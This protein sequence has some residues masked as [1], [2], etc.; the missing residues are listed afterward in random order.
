MDDGQ[1]SAVYRPLW[2]IPASEHPFPMYPLS[3]TEPHLAVKPHAAMKLGSEK[4]I[5]NREE[6]HPKKESA[7]D[8]VPLVIFTLLAQLSVGAFWFM[9]LLLPKPLTILPLSIIGFS[10]GIGM[11]FSFA[12][13]GTKKNAWRV[14]N[15]LNKSWLSREILTAS[16][17]GAGWLAVTVESLTFEQFTPLLLWITALLGF[18]LT[19]S[20]GQVYRLRAKP[21]WNT[22]RT[23][24][25][26]FVSALLL[27]LTISMVAGTHTRNV[28]AIITTCVLLV[29]Q[30]VV[31][32]RF[33][34]QPATRIMQL[35]SYL[36]AV[37]VAVM[38]ILQQEEL[39]TELCLLIFAF[40]L[41]GETICRLQF[42]AAKQTPG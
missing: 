38:G 17:F 24:A 4:K 9:S 7:W 23:N 39:S 35:G 28:A 40:V 3:R 33:H 29:L 19:Y 34:S 42:Y 26:F 32:N 1:S 14:L 11:F 31:S 22:W 12:H 15:H 18:S 2:K 16:L 27:G 5:G 10:L 20:M 37:L 13:L 41:T 25:S 30:A 8:E 6:I 36:S 21:I